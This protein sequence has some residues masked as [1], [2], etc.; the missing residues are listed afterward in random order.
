[1][2]SKD[3]KRLINHFLKNPTATTAK[4]IPEKAQY[5]LTPI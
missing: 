3:I 5:Q 2:E 1:M 4:W